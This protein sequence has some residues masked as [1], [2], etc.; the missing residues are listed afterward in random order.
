MKAPNFIS[1]LITLCIVMLIQGKL[2]SQT[3]PY[4]IVGTG[5][6]QCYGNTTPITCP[7]NTTDA[8][9]GQF[10][11]TTPSY[12]NNGNGTISDLNTG[13]MWVQ[14]RGAKITWD[15]AFIMADQCNVGGY[16]DWRVPTIKELYSLIN[17]NGRSGQYASTCIA[18]LDTTYF[19]FAY[20][21]L[22]IGERIIDAQ[23]WSANQYKG[24]TMM[25]DTTVFGVNFIDGRIKGYPKYVPPTTVTRQKM[26]IR[27]V[28]GN[29]SYGSNNFTDNA[30]STITDHA[31]GLMWAKYDAGVGMN[32]ESALAYAQT[33]NTQNYLG[34]NDWRL[35]FAKELQSLVDYSR[36]LDATASAAINPVFNCT[37]IT[38]E[39]GNTN[40]PFY[41]SAT[42]HLDN[43]GGVYVAF[44]EALGYMKMPPTATYYTLKD[45]HGAGAQRSDPKSGN[46]RSSQFYLGKNQAGDSVFGRGPQGDVQR[47]N[48]FVRLV[49]TVNG[50]E[51]I[52][53]NNNNLWKVYPNPFTDKIHVENTNDKELYELRNLMGQIIWK[54]MQIEKHNFSSLPSGVYFLKVD[55]I[56]TS[57][58]IKLIKK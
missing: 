44:G 25:A 46:P 52:N 18:Y 7:T 27:Y 28:R 57:Q 20:G 13:L 53:E 40:Y 39:G 47:I 5:V 37:A 34:H 32:W 2:Q 9:Y 21:N 51:G 14:A 4:P 43:M 22:S 33:K 56:A 49:R 16:N 1:I 26:H 45:V 38:D 30:D 36:S 58:V 48:N 24:L 10:Q 17:F 23:D 29:P 55:N 35:P 3:L 42:T 11:G 54:G 8:F 15:S 50:S 6:T 12:Q 19:Q 41:W 31:T